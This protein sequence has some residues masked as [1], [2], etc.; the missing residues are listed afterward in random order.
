MFD[1][2]D[3]DPTAVET[4]AAG[5]SIRRQVEEAISA[6][7]GVLDWVPMYTFDRVDPRSQEY[8]QSSLQLAKSIISDISKRAASTQQLGG[9]D[10]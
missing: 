5:R 3:N 4:V 9:L 10:V 6:L 1:E 2:I 7:N 8:I